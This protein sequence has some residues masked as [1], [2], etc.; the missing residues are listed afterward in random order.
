MPRTAK[1]LGLS[2]ELQMYLSGLSD[3]YNRHRQ[4]SSKL[5]IAFVDGA[6]DIQTLHFIHQLFPSLA[7]LLIL[8]L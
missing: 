1:Q 6:N 5:F 3:D 2:P 7:F 8:H 4:L